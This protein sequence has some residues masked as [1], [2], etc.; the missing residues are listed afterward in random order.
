MLYPKDRTLAYLLNPDPD[1]PMFQR[2][3]STFR[4]ELHRRFTEWVYPHRFRADRAR[5]GRRRALAS[6]EPDQPAGHGRRRSR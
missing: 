6:R 4:A 3:R 1:D 2:S 5:G